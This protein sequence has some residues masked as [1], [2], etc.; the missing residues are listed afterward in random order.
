MRGEAVVRP[1]VGRA[2]RVVPAPGLAALLLAC[3]GGALLPPSAPAE[4]IVPGAAQTRPVALVGGTI[5]TASGPVIPRGVLVFAEGRITALG[6]DAPIPEGAERVDVTGMHVYPG[7]IDAA[8]TVGLTEIGAVRAS[9]DFAEVGGITPEVRAEVAVNPESDLIPVTRTN[10]V[11]AVVTMP[12]GG[13]ICGTS[14]LLGL[15]GWTWRDL[16]LRAPVGMHVNWPRMS[17]DRAPAVPDSTEEKQLL[18]RDRALHDLAQVFEDARAYAQAK[19]AAGGAKTGGGGYA[20]AGN[21]PDLDL[22]WEAMLP[23]LDGKV[24]LVVTADEMLQIES[25]VDFAARERVRLVILGGYDAPRC[26]ALL[27]EHDVPVIVSPVHRSPRRSDEPYDDAYT[28]PVRL[29]DAGV[30]FAIALSSA[31]N[32]RNVTFQASTAVGFG[33]PPDEGLR[34]ITL[35]PAQILGFA[36]R[37]GS[38]EVGKDATLFVSDGDPLE[39]GTRVRSAYISGRM[40]NLTN[41][42][43]LLYEKYRE[44]YRRQGILR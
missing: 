43:T 41:R 19:R 12:T 26:A 4:V 33:L 40:I 39:N 10:G 20:A 28:V 18:E 32:A 25:A 7:M 27:K 36:D 24:P 44:K 2:S 9:N 34:A 31:S 42:Q 37:L 35:Y 21:A 6:P 11:L 14:A 15:D 3:L 8:T 5:H 23:V 17:V 16:T 38:L 30:R 1:G 13:R 22:R 29:H